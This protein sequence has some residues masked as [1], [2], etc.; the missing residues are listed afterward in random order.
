LE[1]FIVQAGFNL[2]RREPAE[3]RPIVTER[4]ICAA[5]GLTGGERAM[6]RAR[7]ARPR[8]LPA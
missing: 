7:A 4:A 8:P 2:G 1:P 3:G 6:R 5:T